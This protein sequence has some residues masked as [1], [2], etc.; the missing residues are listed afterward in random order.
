VPASAAP[1]APVASAPAAPADPGAPESCSSAFLRALRTIEAV[2][3]EVRSD[4]IE[5]DTDGR[6]K[7]RLPFARIEAIAVGAVRGLG[8]RPVVVVDCILN[9][10]DDIGS[11]LKLIRFRSDRFE[12]A[13]VGQTAPGTSAVA[14]LG[15][16]AGQLQRASG[17]ACLPSEAI[18][19]GS[20]ASFGS[21]EDYEREV[22][23][24]ERE[25]GG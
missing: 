15:A 18:L 16:F 13:A 14:A 12:P 19:A 24:A 1:S 8:P 9:W 25:L 20:Y 7:S 2:P 3:V 23:G 4:A 11:P 22:L 17:A 21:L 6:G 5:I 10:R